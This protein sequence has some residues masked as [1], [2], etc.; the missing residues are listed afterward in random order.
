MK[1][2]F[3]DKLISTPWNIDKVRGRTLIASMISKLLKSER[4]PVDDCGDPLPVMRI[5]GDV[6]IIPI[7]GVVK[8]AVPDWIKAWGVNLTDANDIAEEI[9][10]ALGNPDVSMIVLDV[11]SP[12]GS[13]LAGDK[14]FECVERAG[15]SKPVF[16]YVADGCNICS[17]AYLAVAACRAILA[18][19]FA[20]GV[21]CIGSYLALL[22]DTEYWASF[23]FKFHVFR[24]GELKG[25]GE[26]K[27]SPAQAEYLQGLV[28]EAGSTFRKSVRKYRTGVSEE[29]MEGQWFTGKEAAQ[30]G[31]VA[32]N[33]RDLNAAIVKFRGMI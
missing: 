29:D 11:D 1:E 3:I 26:D 5:E 20:S 17:T 9:N 4:P 27:L 16:G 8:I 32:G 23:G 19:P 15:R 7:S 30:R 10:R 12:G 22:D 14:L 13:A 18:G 31:F 2:Q 24:S 6:A 25:I 33:A 21:G 28:D